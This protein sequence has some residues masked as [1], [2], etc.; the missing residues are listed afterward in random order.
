MSFPQVHG[1]LLNPLKIHTLSFDK[2]HANSLLQQGFY[3]I[4][5]A[6]SIPLHWRYIYSLPI[7]IAIYLT[8]HYLARSNSFENWVGKI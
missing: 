4:Q 7:Y 5:Q 1:Y 8:A 2:L 3:F 6:L